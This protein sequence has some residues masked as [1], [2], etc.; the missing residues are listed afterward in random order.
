MKAKDVVPSDSRYIPLTQ[1]RWCCVP[2]CIQ[3]VMYRHKIPLIPAELIG[4]HLGL[5]V[6]EEELQYFWNGRTGKMP[7]ASWGTQISKPE[8]SPNV[9]FKKLKI[10]LKMELKLISG[11]KNLQT[12]KEYLREVESRDK[13][14][15]VCFDYGTLYNT[16]YH[17]GHVCVLDRVYL[18]KGEFR[19]I[20]TEYKS[21]KWR[22]VK[23]DKLYSAMKIHGD[24]KSGG[25][26]E[27]I[28]TSTN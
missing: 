6:P 11:F 24:V 13:D 10:P 23:V 25:F 9:V 26:W 1:Q 16:D 3:I 19:L 28:R 2:T 21:P 27:L 14:V 18:S 15:L 7:V 4:Y 22:V 5:I 17:G 8:F 12:F 20:D